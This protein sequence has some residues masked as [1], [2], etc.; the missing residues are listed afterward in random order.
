MVH[1]AQVNLLLS[2][3]PSFGC[4]P[5]IQV[6]RPLRPLSLSPPYHGCAWRGYYGVDDHGVHDAYGAHG[7]RGGSQ[8]EAHHRSSR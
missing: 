8:R 2:P 4:H 1:I 5:R 7:D 6:A 3:L